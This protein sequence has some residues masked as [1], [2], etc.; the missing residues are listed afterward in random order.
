M[1][2][3]KSQQSGEVPGD[4]K[5]GNITPTFKKGRKQHPRNYQPV[6]LTYVPEKIMEQILLAML[7]HME[8][9]EVIRDNQHGFTKLSGAVNTAD[10]QDAIQRDLDKLEK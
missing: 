1:I 3:G 10:G 7:R 9:R 8:D 4:W 2:L 6:S 5:K